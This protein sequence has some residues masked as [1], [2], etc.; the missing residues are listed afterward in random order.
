MFVYI[1]NYF[2]YICYHYL[3]LLLSCFKFHCE[4]CLALGAG[5]S[6]TKGE[7]VVGPFFP[8]TV[9]CPTVSPEYYWNI[10]V[11][12]FLRLYTWYKINPIFITVFIYIKN[13]R[14]TNIISKPG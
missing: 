6:S 11:K 12:H 2:Y 7:F 3:M 13:N 1:P 4:K 5:V 8:Q 14:L 10:I 9:S